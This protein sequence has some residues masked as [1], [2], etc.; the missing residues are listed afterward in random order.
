MSAAA[1][2]RTA[3][4]WPSKIRLVGPLASAVTTALSRPRSAGQADYWNRA[5]ARRWIVN[6]DILDQAAPAGL[7]S[8]HGGGFASACP[9]V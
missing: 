9:R 3:S 1:A 7:Y 6:L 5:G 4:L 8:S 2:A